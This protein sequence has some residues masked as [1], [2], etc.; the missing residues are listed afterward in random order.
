MIRRPP[1]STLSSS[2]AASDV[3]KRQQQSA[4]KRAGFGRSHHS[5]TSSI[6]GC[7]DCYF[8]TP[9]T[10]VTQ[11]MTIV[12]H[13]VRWRGIL[14]STCGLRWGGKMRCFVV[15]CLL[16]TIVILNFQIE[17]NRKHR[18]SC[19]VC[20]INRLYRLHCQISNGCIG[21]IVPLVILVTFVTLVIL[22]LIHI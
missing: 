4:P 16:Q 22:S 1:R 7:A 11:F 15:R 17:V 14:L 20:S 18:F 3:Y 21:R 5:R 2:S 13:R 10:N 19:I 12:G 8:A 9:T 6:G